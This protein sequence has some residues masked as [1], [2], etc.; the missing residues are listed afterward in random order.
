MTAISTSPS[1]EEAARKI[2]ADKFIVSSDPE[3]MKAGENSLDLILNTVSAPH[4]L[5]AYVPLLVNI[6]PSYVENY[7]K[8]LKKQTFFLEARR[9]SGSAWASSIRSFG[10]TDAPHDEVSVLI[11]NAYILVYFLNVMKELSTIPL[12]NI[13]I[14]QSI[15]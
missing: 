10:S 15:F 5:N 14:L 1:K 3:K 8:N 9:N 6:Y 11:F 4:Q 7:I 2:G 12:L 13:R